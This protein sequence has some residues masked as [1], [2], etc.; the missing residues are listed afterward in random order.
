M[1]LL[2][3]VPLT[4]SFNHLVAREEILEHVP[5]GEIQLEDMVVEVKHVDV[6]LGQPARVSLVLSALQP[7]DVDDVDELK[8]IIIR[9][10]GRP[11]QLEVQS[12]LRR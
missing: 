6:A 1:L 7:I 9:Q 8:A 12:N 10:L 5:L 4:L 3:S 2:I 11:I